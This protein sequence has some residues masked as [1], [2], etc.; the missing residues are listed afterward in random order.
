MLVTVIL[1]F[2]I[3]ETTEGLDAFGKGAMAINMDDPLKNFSGSKE[4]EE[5]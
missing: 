3:T 4:F 1:Y 2:L 5:D